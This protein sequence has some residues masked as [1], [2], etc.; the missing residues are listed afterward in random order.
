MS[1][2]F[3]YLYILV[4]G[5]VLGSFYNVVGLRLTKS[6]SIVYPPSHC[7]KCQKRLRVYELIPVLSYLI[8]RGRCRQCNEPISPVYPFFEAITGLLFVFAFYRVGFDVELVVAWLLISLLVI[9]TV[10]DW[11]EQIIPDR[12]LAF[13]VLVFVI[14]RLWL[15]LDPWYDAYLGAALGFGLLFVIALISRGGMGGG[16]IKLFGVLGLVLGIQGV[17]LTLMLASLIGSFIGIALIAFSKVKRGMPIAFGP[18]I[19]IA[20]LVTYFYGDSLINWYWQLF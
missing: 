13:F 20:A 17:L 18:F 16:D 6:E 7:P 9:I 8:Q 15:P 10:S 12:V 2:L 14:I 5:L 19:A 11:H 4:L 3:I 1:L